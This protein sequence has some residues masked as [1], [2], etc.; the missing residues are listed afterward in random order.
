M[1]TNFDPETAKQNSDV[2]RAAK[3]ALLR[4][5]AHNTMERTD[6][7]AEEVKA[8][9]ARFGQTASWPEPQRPSKA[10]LPK[11]NQPVRDVRDQPSDQADSGKEIILLSL[12]RLRPNGKAVVR[13]RDDRARLAQRPRS[14][15]SC[16]PRSE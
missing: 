11:P 3:L 16:Q 8:A 10:V 4:I 15:R 2:Y 1:I 14:A 5:Q 12:A 6:A 13:S 9:L 7:S